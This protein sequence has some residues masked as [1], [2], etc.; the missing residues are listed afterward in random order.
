MFRNLSCRLSLLAAFL[1]AGVALAADKPD[2]PAFFR[3]LNLNGPPVE[4]DG[5][6]WEGKDSADYDCRDKAFE[7]QD[8]K[9]VPETDAERAKMIKSSRWGG[10]KV[11]LKNV[12]P[13]K[14]SFF[15]YVW[16]DNND[17]VL[18][19]FLNGKLVAKQ[20]HSGSTGHWERLG[21]WLCDATK[22]RELVLTSK[23][24]AANF[25]G[26]EVWRGQYD[27]LPETTAE[28]LEF[29]EAKV[30]PVLIKHC[31][32]CHSAASKEVQGEL[33]VDSRKAIRAGGSTG[34]AVVPGDLEK[35]LLIKAIRH[36]DPDLKMPP[37]EK[38]SAAEIADLEQ[39]VK[40]YAADPRTEDT[41]AVVR[42]KSNIDSVSPPR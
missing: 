8:V 26:I 40:T 11:V 6:A 35:S 20:H 27:G 25:S 22:D 16:E 39:W 7:N 36:T 24:G 37:E 42:A 14:Y 13:G 3:G 10:N 29:F 2:H 17:E 21:P 18:D 23:G 19:I 33:L 31:Y 4:I 12:P 28:Q 34:P 15:L 1:S 41:Q 30:R 32:E 9:L 38:L 5:H